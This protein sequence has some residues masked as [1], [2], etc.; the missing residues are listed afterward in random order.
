M[1]ARKVEQAL[2]VIKHGS[3]EVKEAVLKNEM[4]IN[5]A[6]QNTQAERKKA[7]AES[8]VETS[9]QRITDQGQDSHK[10]DESQ[11]SKFHAPIFISIEHFGA[12]HE[13]GGSVEDHLATAIERYLES[14]N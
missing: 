4:S 3:P 5:R 7:E 2:T 9:K 10:E 1:S 6:Y 8:S 13:L 14:L 12:L 11:V